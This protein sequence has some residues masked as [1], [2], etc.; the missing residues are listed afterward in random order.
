VL[1]GELKISPKVVSLESYVKKKKIKPENVLNGKSALV[2]N[3]LIIP[4][5]HYINPYKFKYH[6]D[7]SGFIFRASRI[8]DS[9]PS[10]YIFKKHRYSFDNFD[11]YKKIFRFKE[12]LGKASALLKE[13]GEQEAYYTVRIFNPH[14]FDPSVGSLLENLAAN[15]SVWKGLIVFTKK[16]V[17]FVSGESTKRRHIYRTA[18]PERLPFYSVI[19]N[20]KE[21]IPVHDRLFNLR[22][23]NIKRKF[24]DFIGESNSYE[25]YNIEVVNGKEIK[26][27][28]KGNYRKYLKKEEEYL[29][30]KGK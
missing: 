4:G 30:N 24:L 19:E 27:P 13:S 5:S 17:Y 6:V 29:K 14:P 28:I 16:Y 7:D 2:N 20:E 12:P 18:S 25:G 23:S 11:F 21:A 9:N 15:T 3:I 1:A 8:E 26:I 10:F 22:D